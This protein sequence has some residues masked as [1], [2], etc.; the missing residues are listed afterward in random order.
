MDDIIKVP[1][2]LIPKQGNDLSKWSVVACDQY[3]SE[4]EYWDRTERSIG[5]APST[6]NI[7]FPEAYLGKG[8][9]QDRIGNINRTMKTYLDN[10]LEMKKG[11]VFI[12]RK[13]SGGK[14]RKGLLICIDLE[15]YDY[16]PFTDAP[17]RAT[18]GTVLDR[19]PPRIRIRENACLECPHILFLIDDKKKTVIEP[20]SAIRNTLKKI[21]STKLIENGGSVEGYLIDETAVQNKIIKNIY[22]LER[23][24]F[25]FAVGDGNHSLATAKEIWKKLKTGLNE[26]EIKDHPA[27][28]ALVE[29]VNLYDDGLVFEPIHRV[30]FGAD[31]FLDTYETY[32]QKP[33]ADGSHIIEYIKDGKN[34]YM[35]FRDPKHNLPV[36]TLQEAIDAYLSKNKNAWVDYIHGGEVVKKL[37]VGNNIGFLL[38]PMKKEEL[39]ET[40][41]KDGV[42]PR[43][44][45]S[46]GE[47]HDKRYYLECR[48]ITPSV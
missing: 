10:V 3:T 4:P 40:V 15:A 18:E 43:K 2:I 9:E 13:M 20:L 25:I 42:L 24:G 29:T 16:T 21:Y 23:D 8:N 35:I 32:E 5:T 31:N 48:R 46:M 41:K 26:Q 6:L 45:F 1:D 7:I 34:G 28:Y 47:A 22:A 37:S 14:T 27:R 33:Q 44:T 11:F 19:L 17:I 38:E 12:E 36:G 30:L 39:F